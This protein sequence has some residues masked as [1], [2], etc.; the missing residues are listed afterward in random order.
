MPSH[1]R[2]LWACPRA[3][4]LISSVCLDVL[5]VGVTSRSRFK[6]SSRRCQRLLVLK[7]QCTQILG[8]R[9]CPQCLHALMPFRLTCQRALAPQIPSLP[10]YRRDVY[11]PGCLRFYMPSCSTS[12]LCKKHVFREIRLFDLT[13]AAHCS[14]FSPSQRRINW[15]T[16]E[17]NWSN[18][19]IPKQAI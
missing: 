17:L 1:R 14:L 4:M 5:N 16:T 11:V 18:G 2:Y 13:H 7:Y 15:E 3:Y 6:I 10:F 9:Y 12:F 8:I 19:L